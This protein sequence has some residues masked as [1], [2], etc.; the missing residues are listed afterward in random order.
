MIQKTKLKKVFNQKGLQITPAAIEMI[1]DDIQRQLNTMA[2]RCL[3]GNVKR[4]TPELMWVAL[5]RLNV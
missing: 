3:E 4:L 5:G 1:D 2:N